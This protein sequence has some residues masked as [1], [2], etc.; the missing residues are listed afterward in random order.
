MTLP[1]PDVF[2]S[3]ANL[4]GFGV[5]IWLPMRLNP[6]GPFY[7]SHPFVGV[8]RLKAGVTVADANSEIAAMTRRLPEIVPR[9]YSPGFM[10][11]YNFRGEVS[12]R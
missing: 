5:D 1:M 10:K 12:A 4:A 6:A 2:S 7:N 11:Q 9:A 8:A 3:T